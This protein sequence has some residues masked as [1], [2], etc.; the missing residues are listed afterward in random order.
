MDATPSSHSD[1]AA[2]KRLARIVARSFYSG[3]CPPKSR[4]DTEP[5]GARSKLAKIDTSGL[6]IIL[7]DYLTTKE[8]VPEQEIVDTL[9]V[10]NKLLRKGLKFLERENILMSE[11]RR[12]TRRSQKR[13]VVKAV[14][15]A[16]A[17]AARAE[18]G[19]GSEEE[20]EQLQKAHTISYYAM[21]YPRMFDALQLRLLRMRKD[22]KNELDSKE[23]LAK[24]M[25]LQCNKEFSSMD[26]AYMQAAGSDDLHCDLCNNVVQQVFASG[27]TGDE[28]ERR[29]RR[30]ML[31]ER[32]QM[33]D[34]QL[35]DLEALIKSLRTAVAPYYGTLYEWA[36]RQQQLQQQSQKQQAAQQ[37]QAGAGG[38]KG[39]VRGASGAVHLLAG[40]GAVDVFQ[41]LQVEMNL[42]GSTEATAAAG[43][44]SAAAPAGAPAAPGKPP[45]VPQPMWFNAGRNNA[46]SQGDNTEDDKKDATDQEDDAHKKA[47]YAAWMAQVQAKLKATQQQQL[48]AQPQQ[49]QWQEVEESPE[50]PASKRVKREEV[51]VKQ[52]DA[53]AQ[54]DAG[55]EWEDVDTT[56]AGGDVQ[57]ALQGDIAAPGAD[58]DVEWEEV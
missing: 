58:D 51:E 5:E 57:Q 45:A 15:D 14:M 20:E 24:Y 9:K 29:K 1:V 16:T 38:S 4:D 44:D 27:Q 35:R 7:V 41:D 50:V 39:G 46:A 30:K 36:V 55:H 33:M 10:H 22:L 19:A 43:P 31:Q 6:A 40:Q 42:H 37:R 8:W 53:T 54:D 23:V 12:E 52:E 26:V 17:E 49:Q 28:V 56:P 13:D 34:T 47:Y 48:Q 2:F 21:D 18:E 25:C 11:H 3:Q 32:L